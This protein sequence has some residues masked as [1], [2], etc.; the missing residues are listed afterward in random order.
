MVSAAIGSTGYN[1]MLVLHLASVIVAFAPVFVWPFVSMRLKKTG[2]PVGPTINKLAAGLTLK[3][4]GPALVAVGFFGFALSGMSG[5]GPDGEKIYS[6]SSPW[7]SAAAVLWV[8]GMGIMFGFMVP[9]EKKTVQGDAAAEKML[10]MLG[11][12]LHLI[13]F[14]SLYLMVWK[15]G[16]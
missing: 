5:D 13:L 10:S 7:L 15:P 2:Q 1:I 9:A 12:V 4:H 16:L 6:V 11:G 8:L 3:V 14:V